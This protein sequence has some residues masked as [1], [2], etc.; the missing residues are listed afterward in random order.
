MIEPEI[1]RDHVYTHMDEI[2]VSTRSHVRSRLRLLYETRY[3]GGDEIHERSHVRK[4]GWNHG[5]R[6]VDD[7]RVRA[8]PIELRQNYSRSESS[9][10][11]YIYSIWLEGDSRQCERCTPIARRNGDGGTCRGQDTNSWASPRHIGA[12]SKITYART[13]EVLARPSG[14]RDL[15]D[16][17][18]RRTE[19]KPIPNP[20]FFQLEPEQMDMA[21]WERSDTSSNR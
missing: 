1:H 9:R 5:S 2:G 12:R 20:I 7:G 3:S 13:D 19:Q 6:N 8:E 11:K 16:G 21:R 10:F 18:N 17:S 4:L 15:T 14:E